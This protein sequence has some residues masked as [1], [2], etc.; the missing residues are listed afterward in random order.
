MYEP[1]MENNSEIHT[2]YATG[3]RQIRTLFC[4]Q[5]RSL[6]APFNLNAMTTSPTSGVGCSGRSVSSIPSIVLLLVRESDSNIRIIGTVVT[7]WHRSKAKVNRLLSN[8]PLETRPTH[9]ST[10]PFHPPPLPYDILEMVITYLARDLGALK[11][12]S[13]ISRSWYTAATPHLHHTLTLKENIHDIDRSQMEPL[14]KLHELG[15]LHLV[16]TLRVKQGV[17]NSRWFVPQPF[18]DLD[19]CYFSTLANVH[20]LKLQNVEIHRFIPDL[21]YHFG[22]FS[23]TLRSITLHDP[24]CTPQQLS[25]FLSLFSNLDD[26]GIRNSHRHLPNKTISD[27]ELVPFSVPKLQGRLALDNFTW[28]EVWTHLAASCGGL[29]FRHMDLRMSGSCAPVL[30]EACADTLETLRFDLRGGT[31]GK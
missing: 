28:F 5:A 25:H 31:T 15:L 11:A 24:S 27:T 17:G 12:C 22:R 6:D 19:L 23:Q 14:S 29:R 10:S 3:L 21:E 18:S 9:E 30:F 16:K 2:G 20:T 1:G 7:V 4:L 13:L 8:A 26:I